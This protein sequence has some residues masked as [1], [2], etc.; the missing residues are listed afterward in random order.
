MSIFE[1]SMEKVKLIECPRDA[2]QGWKQPISTA[3]KI[4]YLRTLLR[5][6]FDSLDCGSFVSH[7]AIPQMADTAQ[8]IEAIGP[9]KEQTKLS[10]IVANVRGAEMACAFSEVDVLG[11]PFSISENFQ[12]RNTGKSIQ[13]SLGVLEQIRNQV[14]QKQ[15]DLV[16][17]LSMGFGNPYGDPWHPDII[18][19]WVYRLCELGIRTF[20]LSDTIGKSTPQVIKDVFSTLVPAFPEVEFGA[21]F[22]TTPLQA[23]E[24]IQAAYQSNCRRYDGAIRGVGGCPMA[25][26]A[27]VGNMPMEALITF[28]TAKKCTHGLQL[29]HFESAYNEAL[30]LFQ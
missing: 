15:K 27:L 21:H 29:L 22:H 16:L 24:K 13:E 5:V 8:V 10:V 17:Y 4:R 19:E 6:G 2:M 18:M 12:M 14:E 25:Q 3:D 28:F 11:Y 1:S 20:S 9:F 23:K 7:K 26:D 30:N